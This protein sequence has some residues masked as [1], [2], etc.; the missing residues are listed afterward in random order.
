M[1]KSIKI[2]LLTKLFLCKQTMTIYT[3][4]STNTVI[5]LARMSLVT[6][7]TAI[8][9][10]LKSQNLK[11]YPLRIST[12]VAIT[13]IM[14]TIKRTTMRSPMKNRTANHATITTSFIN[15]AI[16]SVF[17]SL[18]TQVPIVLPS[19]LSYQRKRKASKR[20]KGIGKGPARVP[21]S[22]KGIRN[23]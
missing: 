1:K 23:M 2:V 11:K 8:Y 17:N 18:K 19:R 6:I 4:E 9:L 7:L 10:A 20:L 3:I 13:T 22:R 16:E 15:R 21:N 12:T 5:S 14:S